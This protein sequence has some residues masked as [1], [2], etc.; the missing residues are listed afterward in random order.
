ML[1]GITFA[2]IGL[3]I[4]IVG[5]AY[6][7]ALPMWFFRRRS[8][9]AR[10]LLLISQVAVLF[11]LPWYYPAKPVLLKAIVTLACC[12]ILPPK[13]LDT[14]LHPG[15]WLGRPFHSW[16]VYL[17][18]PFILV[19]RLHSVVPVD[20]AAGRQLAMRGL[21]E[22]ALGGAI[23]WFAFHFIDSRVPFW[24][25]HAIKLLGVYF[26][27][28]DGLF[29]FATGIIRML[30]GRILD[31]S[32]NPAA[33]T[34]PAD[35]WRRY[36]CEAGRFFRE[37][38]FFPVGGRRHS[39]VIAVVTFLINGI[40]HEYLALIMVGRI[41][42]YQVLFFTLHGAATAATLRWRPKGRA[43]VVGV[44]ATALFLYFTSILFFANCD[45]FLQ[46][47]SRE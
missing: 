41:T 26:A 17:V 47:Y 24:L 16:L 21:V 2:N 8:S 28:F 5:G 10:T 30:G 43:R 27:V 18:N 33:A 11:A 1:H 20:P 44:A 15:H 37:D 4:A 25:E 35:F 14:H 42:G 32:R 36:N 46:W 45:M 22:I 12:A 23:L 6:T 34:T 29:V 19:H 3:A 13:L 31:L 7:V 38:V 9:N 40:L 39:L